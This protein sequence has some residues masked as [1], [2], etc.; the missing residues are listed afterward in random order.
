MSTR[1]AA[2][3]GLGS[4]LGDREENLDRGLRA[5]EGRGVRI[6]AESSTYLTEPVGG[7]AQPWYLNRVVEGETA[8]APQELL[9]ACLAVEHS[10]G[11]M[12]VL[13][14][15]PRTLDIDLLLQGQEVVRSEALTLPHPRFHER[16]FVLVPLCEIAPSA[17][18]PVLGLT[19]AELLA[20]CPD[21]STVTLHRLARGEA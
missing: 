16:R 14:N 2:F 15:A 9:S 6:V 19:A 20:R 12:R 13:K 11:R 4:N 7:P 5:L 21:P 3:L 8:L 18:H 10:L 17:R 1:Q